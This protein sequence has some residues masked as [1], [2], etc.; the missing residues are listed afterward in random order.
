[1]KKCPYC[2]T[3]YPDDTA[4]CAIDQTPFEQETL[5]SREILNRTLQSATGRAITTGL[6]IFFMN[7]GIYCLAGRLDLEI[8]KIFHHSYV[9]PLGAKEIIEMSVFVKW[10]LIVGFAFFTFG[11][12]SARSGKVWQGIMIAMITYAITLLFMSPGMPLVIL[13][14]AFLFGFITNSSVGYFFGSALQFVAGAFLLGWMGQ[15]RI[16]KAAAP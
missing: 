10:L 3:E 16:R 2:G 7:T 13:V 9:L 5:Q 12:C 11:V 6:A 4:V 8:S 1:M 14:P 15:P